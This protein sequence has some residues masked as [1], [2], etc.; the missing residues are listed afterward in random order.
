MAEKIFCIGEMNFSKQYTNIARKF[1]NIFVPQ[2]I[3]CGIISCGREN[4]LHRRDEF[5]EA[6]YEYYKKFHQYF[7]APIHPLGDHELW[8]RKYSA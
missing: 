7:Y 2:S 6:I 1:T 8:Q 3:L 5:F 4:I